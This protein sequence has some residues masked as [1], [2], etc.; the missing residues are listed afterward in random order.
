MTGVANLESKGAVA[1]E[2]RLAVFVRG[3]SPEASARSN[4]SSANRD[5]RVSVYSQ[6]PQRRVAHFPAAKI[7][8]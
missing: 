6:R 5:A 2:M 3:A 4:I 7:K 8:G 1:V